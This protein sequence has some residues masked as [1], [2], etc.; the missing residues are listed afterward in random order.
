MA[1]PAEGAQLPLGGADVVVL[2]HQ[3][4]GE[5]DT[6]LE[7]PC[8]GELILPLGVLGGGRRR[9]HE[10][11]WPSGP[12]GAVARRKFALDLRKCVVVEMV[13]EGVEIHR[14]RVRKRELQNTRD[15][16]KKP[17]NDGFS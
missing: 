4:L 12:S 13:E 11:Q 16:R 2:D 8:A 1:D 7:V 14:Q 9:V 10:V 5:S 3:R 17:A 15:C 6:P